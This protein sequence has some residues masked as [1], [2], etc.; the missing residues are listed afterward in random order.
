LTICDIELTARAPLPKRYPINASTMGEFLRQYRLAHGFTQFEVGLE[1]GV[2]NDTVHRWEI[3]KIKPQPKNINKIINM[4][5]YDPR[6]Y[7]PLK[8][9]NYEYYEK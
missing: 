7:N 5:G 2:N 8:H 9:T 1:L 3:G 6:I 4:M